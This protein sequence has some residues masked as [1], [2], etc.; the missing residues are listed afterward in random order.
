[1][2]S[3]RFLHP[4]E[5]ELLDAASYYELQSPGLGYDFLGMIDSAVSD[6]GEHPTRWPVIRNDIRRRIIHRFPYALMYRIE[7]EE[8]VILATMHLH[9]HPDYWTNRR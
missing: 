3:I 6:I 4:A 2:K 5:Q 1:M 8:I 7:S 9:K